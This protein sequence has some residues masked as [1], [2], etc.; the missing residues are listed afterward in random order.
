MPRLSSLGLSRFSQV[1]CLTLQDRTANAWAK[2]SRSYSGKTQKGPWVGPE[3]PGCREVVW[4]SPCSSFTAHTMRSTQAAFAWQRS[5][6]GLMSLWILSASCRILWSSPW[7]MLNCSN[8]KSW[9]SFTKEVGRSVGKKVWDGVG[10]SRRW[11][12]LY[13]TGG[14][15][16]WR[17]TFPLNK[18][19]GDL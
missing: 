14:R 19:N 9:V 16:Q 15:C 10:D 8:T 11:K 12:E 1:H 4:D 3:L 2:S 5:L 13:N 18:T 7:L 6:S 17:R